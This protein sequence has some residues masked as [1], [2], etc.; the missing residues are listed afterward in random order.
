MS[1]RPRAVVVHRRTELQELLRHHGT[2]GQAAFFLKSRGRSLDEVTERDQAVRAAI[3]AVT[4]VIPADWRR[5][6]VERADLPIRRRPRERCWPP[7][8]GRAPLRPRSSSA[9]SRR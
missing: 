8:P 2:A 3:T 6:L 5:G 1:L 4:S 9:W 7:R